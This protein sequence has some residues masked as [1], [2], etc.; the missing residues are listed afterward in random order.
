MYKSLL[1]SYKKDLLVIELSL[2][3]SDGK[4]HS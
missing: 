4:Y 1:V 3:G 2:F